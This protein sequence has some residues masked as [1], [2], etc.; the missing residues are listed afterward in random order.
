MIRIFTIFL[1]TLCLACSHKSIEDKWRS[2]AMSSYIDFKLWESARMMNAIDF[3]GPVL[4]DSIETFPPDTTEIV[5]AWYY[6]HE[7]DTFW[8]YS[9]VDKSG[10]REP[11]I[12]LSKNYDELKLNWETWI[13]EKN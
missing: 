8:I 7:K 9:N 13:K 10:E 4:R 11:D 1:L 2:K 6:V 5:Y 3:T 12:H